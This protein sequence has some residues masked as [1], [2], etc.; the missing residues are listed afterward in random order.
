[1]CLNMMEF[2]GKE[3]LVKKISEGIR[4]E[5]QLMEYMDLAYHLAT[6]PE[7]KETILG[8]MEAMTP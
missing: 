5:D 4:R 7:L 6:E 1:M 2:E 8:D 3:A